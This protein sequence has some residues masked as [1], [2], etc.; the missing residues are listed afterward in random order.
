MMAKDQDWVWDSLWMNAGQ[1][2]QKTSDGSLDYDI[3]GVLF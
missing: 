3:Q 2:V 1:R